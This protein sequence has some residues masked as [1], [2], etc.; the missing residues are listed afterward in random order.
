MMPPTHALTGMLVAAVWHSVLPGSL[1]LLILAGGI[2][3][4]LPDVDM[5][6]H[7]RQ[8]LHYPV[9]YGVAAVFIGL[10]TFTAHSAFLSLMFVGVLAAWLH[11]VMDIFAGAELRSWDRS[12][13]RQE[14]V[15]NHVE[16]AWI[17]PRRWV[18]GGTARD[19]LLSTAAGS[20]LLFF[21]PASFTVP[22]L[23]VMGLAVVQSI[24]MKPLASLVPEQFDTW[25]QYIQHK[26][27]GEIRYTTRH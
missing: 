19:L 13:W 24:A 4:A 21:L 2:G 10:L 18:H 20:A 9:L 8:G 3:G 12:E 22:V 14:A 27:F 26:V 16:Q 17:P 5:L 25:E 15:Y 11:S 6:Y 23:L 1:P 7:H